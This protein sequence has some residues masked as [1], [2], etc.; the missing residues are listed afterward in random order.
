MAGLGEACSHISALLFTAEANTQFRN[1]TSCTSTL[2]SWT[3]VNTKKCE[4]APICKTDF[5]TTQKRRKT[6]NGFL[7]TVPLSTVHNQ[8]PTEEK[9]LE[10]Y[11][12][13]SSEC[14]KKSCNIINCTRRPGFCDMHVP[15]SESGCL[16]NP[17]SSLFNE[18]FLCTLFLQLLERSKEVFPNI[19]IS[20][21]QVK[22]PEKSTID[23]SHCKL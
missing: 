5:T 22:L 17:L 1:D 7:N 11:R 6:T 21:E 16:P 10:F 19:T 4:Y 8:E 14:E 18:R 23:Q 20:S 13:L 2:C 15:Q 9:L 12:Q 3:A